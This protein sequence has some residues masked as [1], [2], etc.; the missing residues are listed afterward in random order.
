M[1]PAGP[2]TVIAVAAVILT[3]AKW[4][5]LILLLT[6]S[7]ACFAAAGSAL[8]R[9]HQVKAAEREGLRWRADE[10]DLAYRY[11][12]YGDYEPAT[13]VLYGSKIHQAMEAYEQ[14]GREWY[15]YQ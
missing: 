5:I 12:V 3:Y 6:F 8:Y 11:G 9:R 4:I 10:Q 1:K 7:V 13:E 15:D 2:W 14:E